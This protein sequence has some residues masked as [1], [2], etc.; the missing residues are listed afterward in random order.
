MASLKD[1]ESRIKAISKTSSITQ[2]MHNIA[3]SKLKKTNELL[4]SYYQFMKELN[5]V[6]F[7]VAARQSNHRFVKKDTKMT[8]NK[9]YIV[10][11]GDRGLAGS[12]HQQVFKY[13]EEIQ[14]ADTNPL[15]LL[16]IGKKG[17]Y[18]AQKR[19]YN[20]LNTQYISSRDD[21]ETV[22]YNRYV[23]IIKEEF[24][25]GNI[26]EVY[27]VYNHYINSAS[28]KV[29]KEILL[30][31]PVSQTAVEKRKNIDF[32]YDNNPKEV[33]ENLIAIYIQ[34]RVFGVMVDGK[35]SELSSRMVS[36]KNATDNAKQV[37]KELQMVYHRARQQ[38]I[39][40]ELIDIVNGSLL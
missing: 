13:L 9:L 18:H 32:E 36:M 2:A 6:L 28:F 25:K 10:I 17:F 31:I 21:L 24:L 15:N 38:K 12:Y 29:K 8:P 16:V 30:P 23:E 7:D 14:S 22:S 35:L 5:I 11:T 33:L 3:A 20:L 39:T 26:D 40:T 37:I 19:K 4:D 34:S 1:I 27:L